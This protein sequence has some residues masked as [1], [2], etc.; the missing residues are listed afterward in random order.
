MTMP[1]TSRGVCSYDHASYTGWAVYCESTGRAAYYD[2]A[3]YT[4]TGVCAMTT[5][6]ILVEAC[7]YQD[8]APIPVE[9]FVV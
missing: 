8:S 6:P 9:V 4:G 1:Y 2:I 3:S 7:A 5:S